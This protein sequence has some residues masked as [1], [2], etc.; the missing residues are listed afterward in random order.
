MEDLTD[1]REMPVEREVQ[2]SEEDE[3]KLLVSLL[4]TGPPLAALP[5]SSLEELA[6][7]STLV[8]RRHRQHPP[9]TSL[10]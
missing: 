4:A 2:S 1:E 9:Q 10:S 6:R 3:P 7:G 8:E 5:P